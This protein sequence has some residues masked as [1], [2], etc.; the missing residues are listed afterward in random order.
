MHGHVHIGIPAERRSAEGSLA[1]IQV[2]PLRYT[3]DEFALLVRDEV[4]KRQT[5]IVMLDSVSGYRLSV[6]DQDL[7]THLHA[8]AKYLQ[9]MGVAVLLINEVESIIGDFRVTDVG[10]S[11]M[12]D[13]ILFLRYIELRGEM[14]K[15]LG[16][17][18][19]RM[20]DF[21]KTLREIRVTGSG[22]EIG[23]PLRGLR[24]ILTGAPEW[25]EAAE[26]RTT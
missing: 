10:V 25:H 8:L 19:K 11:Y 9:S 26:A 14:A 12:A 21:E 16:V 20:G 22:I 4:E 15:T 5:R 6:R 18:K 3:A 7:I 1:L 2:E 23:K 13:N 24:G 17:L